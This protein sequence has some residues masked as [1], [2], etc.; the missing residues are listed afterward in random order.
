MRNAVAKAIMKSKKCPVIDHD[1]IEAL[2]VSFG[3]SWI[4]AMRKSRSQFLNV[5]EATV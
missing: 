3:V 2:F 1:V 5:S 4:K